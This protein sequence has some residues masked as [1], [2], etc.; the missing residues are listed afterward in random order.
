ME[1]KLK[2]LEICQSVISRMA[3]NSFFLKGWSVT[4][5]VGLFALAAQGANVR[6]VYVAYIPTLLFWLL[7]AYYLR[8][9]RLFRKLYDQIRLMEETNID[10]SMN[11]SDFQDAVNSQ[12]RIM[13]SISEVPFYGALLSIILLM[14]VIL[15]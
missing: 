2:H 10:F 11:T 9:E 7:D 8:Q 14:T 12:F 15:H 4:L 3:G 6:F 1:K 5:I 13:F